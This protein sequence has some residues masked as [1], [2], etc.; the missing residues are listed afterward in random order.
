MITLFGL[1][2]NLSPK[3]AFSALAATGLG[4]L[5]LSYLG[6]GDDDPRVQVVAQVVVTGVPSETAAGYGLLEVFDLGIL[7]NY[8]TLPR[9]PATEPLGYALCC[10]RC[11][12]TSPVRA[13]VESGG[14][15]LFDASK[16]GAWHRPD[17]TFR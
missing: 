4:L 11:D 6:G 7:T 1:Q 5:G 2:P 15:L 14:S 12:S 9:R 8:S 13:A 10:R 17:C 3:M 16:L